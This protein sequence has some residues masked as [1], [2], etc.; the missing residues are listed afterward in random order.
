[1][2]VLLSDDTDYARIFYVN[3]LYSASTY[4][5]PVIAWIPKKD[6]TDPF[7]EK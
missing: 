1:M 5:K 7:P 2:V 6:L 4:T 3:Q